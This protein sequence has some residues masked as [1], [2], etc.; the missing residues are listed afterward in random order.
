MTNKDK[1]AGRCPFC[2]GKVKQTIGF[3]RHTLFYCQN[4]ECGAIVSFNTPE[5]DFSTAVARR[6]FNQRA[7][8]KL[9]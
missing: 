3:L 4:R 8:E 5:C 9:C 2:G 1:I 7:G 6:H